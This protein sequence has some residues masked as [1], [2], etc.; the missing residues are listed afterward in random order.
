MAAPSLSI[1]AGLLSSGNQAETD[2]EIQDQA[3]AAAVGAAAAPALTQILYDSEHQQAPYQVTFISIS[4]RRHEGLVQLPGSDESA[5]IC[6]ESQPYGVKLVEWAVARLRYPPKVPAPEPNSNE[7]LME[8][9]VNPIAMSVMP[10]AITP[11]YYRK[12]FY[13]YAFVIPPDHQSK[14]LPSPKNPALSVD[15]PA[16]LTSDYVTGI[17]PPVEED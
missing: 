15:T 12:G 8:Q 5:V 6:R 10:D 9:E 4:Y 11:V 7:E 13:R 16:V 17:A 14:D 2:Q 1:L 3:A